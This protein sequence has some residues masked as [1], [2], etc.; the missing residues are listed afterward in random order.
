MPPLHVFAARGEHAQFGG[1]FHLVIQRTFTLVTDIVVHD[2]LLLHAKMQRLWH[3]DA[4]QVAGG[5]HLITRSDRGHE[6]WDVLRAFPVPPRPLSGTAFGGKRTSLAMTNSPQLLDRLA[7]LTAAIRNQEDVNAANVESFFVTL[8]KE[9]R[10][11]GVEESAWIVF[12]T[13]EA[14][15][16]VFGWSKV[17]GQWDF[18]LGNRETFPEPDSGETILYGSAEKVIHECNRFQQAHA[19]Q[20]SE[21]LLEELCRLLESRYDRSKSDGDRIVQMIRRIAEILRS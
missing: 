7:E 18:A 10:R 21:A 5:V 14:A 4:A 8:A 19:L 17:D 9:L 3:I 12:D 15:D 16:Q 20:R 1:T 2:G 6:P 11:I 13:S